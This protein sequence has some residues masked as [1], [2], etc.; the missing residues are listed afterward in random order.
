[1]PPPD[2]GSF[3]VVIVI[4]VDPGRRLAQ[5]RRS[6]SVGRDLRP[7]PPPAMSATV[8]GDRSSEEQ[9]GPTVAPGHGGIEATAVDLIRRKRDGGALT[10]AQIAWFID[11][12]TNDGPVADE[13]AAA[14]AMAIYFQG[15]DP[16]ELLAWT[17]SMVDSGRRLD[18]GA[19]GRPTVDKHSTGGVG[20]K[21]SL[22]LVPLVA[23][24]GAAVPQ[25]S[26]RGL[27]HT[28]GTL[29]K[30]E[31]IP[32]WRSQLSEDEIRAQLGQ[33]GAV[34]A[35]ASHTLAPADRKLYA[36]RD[37]TATIESIPLIASSIMAKKIAE[38]TGALVLDVKTG[39][40]AFMTD[41]DRAREL[42]VTM[43]QL[44]RAFDLPTT[45]VITS[46]DDLLGRTAGNSLEVAEAIAVLAG[47][48]PADVVELTVSL[49]A[50]M[51]ELVGIEADPAAVLA[52]GEA[53][54]VF[55]RLVRAQGGDLDAGLP[56]A[57]LQAVVRAEADGYVVGIDARTVGVT[58][59]QLGAGRSA[60][61]EP[62]SASAGVRSLVAVGDPVAR[63][64]AVLEL[65]AEDRAHLDRGLR[66]ASTAVAIGPEPPT[67]APRVLER[68]TST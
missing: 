68:I 52:S 40:G 37:V 42:A 4:I 66:T 25:L 47:G 62:V 48:G 57:P 23:A 38:G 16:T 14:M 19:L 63:G 31:S 45:A 39:G 55:G 22:T 53:H 27:G 6:R 58:A 60:K 21:I 67:R 28:G 30:L 12:Y 33:V 36:L 24:C 61:D 20:D 5:S 1:M 17:R 49:A 59:W 46:M 56:V 26:G 2:V 44:G 10:A 50:E 34:I 9:G 8:D 7:Y 51:L 29:D 15:L 13:Q 43:V 54:E 35:G 65:H 64:D 11:Q 32:G 41:R 3:I 18:L